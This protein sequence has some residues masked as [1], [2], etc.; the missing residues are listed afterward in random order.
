VVSE[1]TGGR[2][3]SIDGCDE[4]PVYEALWFFQTLSGRPWQSSKLLCPAGAEEFAKQHG[5]GVPS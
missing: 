3:C 4:R 5:L 1:I 2:P